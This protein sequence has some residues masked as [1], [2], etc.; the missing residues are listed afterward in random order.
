MSDEIIQRTDALIKKMKR[1]RNIGAALVIVGALFV[2]LSF[3]T[4]SSTSYRFFPDGQGGVIPYPTS[5]TTHPLM[6]M[7]A[8]GIAFLIAGIALIASSRRRLK[9]MRNERNGVEAMTAPIEA[10]IPREQASID[11][12]PGQTIEERSKGKFCRFCGAR[13]EAGDSFCSDC[14]K[15]IS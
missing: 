2:L 8:P 10:T 4:S 7:I 1:R 9:K 14:G 15:R 12:N 13:L 5:S 6:F 11:E 3:I